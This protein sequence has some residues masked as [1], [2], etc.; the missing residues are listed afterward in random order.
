MRS[1]KPAP[2]VGTKIS[3]FSRKYF[4]TLALLAMAVMSSYYW[5]G[6][7]YDNLC[8]NEFSSED[9]IGTWELRVPGKPINLTVG[10]DSPSF[11]YCNQNIFTYGF[12]YTSRLQPEEGEWMSAD[13]ERMTDLF[14]WSTMSIIVAILAYFLWWAYVDWRDQRYGN[15]ECRGD[16]QNIPYSKVESIAAYI[17]QV[18]SDA[19]PCPLLACRLGESSSG[20]LDW[21]DPDKPHTYYDMTFDAEILLQELDVSA[22]HVFARLQYYPPETKKAI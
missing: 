1:W 19:F 2:S 10:V 14:G 17:P 3:Q 16:D 5:T 18:R 12:P 13:Q 6:F 20:L 9:H 15:Y 7:P 21:R 4:F 11:R 8:E 22:K